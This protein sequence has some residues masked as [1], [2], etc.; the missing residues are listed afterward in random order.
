MRVEQGYCSFKRTE[1]CFFEWRVL[2]AI[3]QLNLTA[4]VII[5]VSVETRT[6][7]AWIFLFVSSTLL[8]FFSVLSVCLIKYYTRSKFGVTSFSSDLEVFKP[9]E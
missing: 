2:E 1:C 9:S 7:F 4:S 6:I 8:E 3:K 5:S